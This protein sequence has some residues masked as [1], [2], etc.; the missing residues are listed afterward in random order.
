MCRMIARERHICECL[1]KMNSWN[2]H[3]WHFCQILPYAIFSLIV[4]KRKK[5]C[6]CVAGFVLFIYQ[7]VSVFGLKLKICNKVAFWFFCGVL[8]SDLRISPCFAGVQKSDL[9]LQI[10]R[11]SSLQILILE[12]MSILSVPKYPN[13]TCKVSNCL[14]YLSFYSDADFKFVMRDWNR[15]VYCCC[16]QNFTALRSS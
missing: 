3:F 10:I 5:V 2:R 7:N 15:G 1:S 14:S 16:Y 8:T 9:F 13:R 6:G 4:A 12:T 11:V